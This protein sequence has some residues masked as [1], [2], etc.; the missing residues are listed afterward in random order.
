M[1]LSDR[2]CNYTDASITVNTRSHKF[3]NEI[4]DLLCR[5]KTLTV[6]QSLTLQRPCFSRCFCKSSIARIRAESE[7]FFQNRPDSDPKRDPSHR[8]QSRFSASDLDLTQQ[9]GFLLPFQQWK[10][11]PARELQ[12]ASVR[13]NRLRSLGLQTLSLVV[14]KFAESNR[15]GQTP[16]EQRRLAGFFEPHGR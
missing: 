3:L 1:S 4:D 16:L 15:T 7:S 8:F 10:F 2:I 11:N 6:R 9:F 14:R 12:A 5:G 13:N